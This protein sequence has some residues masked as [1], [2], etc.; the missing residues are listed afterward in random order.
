MLSGHVIS[1]IPDKMKT[2][3]SAGAREPLQ[4]TR[5]TYITVALSVGVNIEWLANI[6]GVAL[7]QSKGIM[8]ETSGM[9]KAVL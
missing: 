9:R 7:R 1:D 3:A 4:E 5:H 8:A 2:G 6:A